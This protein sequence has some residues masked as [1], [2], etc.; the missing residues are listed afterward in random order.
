L[1]I[2][3]LSS[4][5]FKVVWSCI[6]TLQYLGA[7]LKFKVDAFAILTVVSEGWLKHLIRG[8]IILRPRVRYR[9]IWE[10][11]FKIDIKNVF[12]PKSADW[13]QVA[14]SPGF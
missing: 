4:A 3:L 9:L 2:H 12:P 1:I 7:A 6:V 14:Q 13:N 11:N 10:S 5:E 8:H